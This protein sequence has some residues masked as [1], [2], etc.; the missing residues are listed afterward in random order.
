MDRFISRHL[1]SSDTVVTAGHCVR[2]ETCGNLV[3][4]FDFV[5]LGPIP[6]DIQITNISQDRV[7]FCKEIV[8]FRNDQVTDFAVVKVRLVSE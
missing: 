2:G 6:T 1:T 5:Q 3:F 8:A 7:Y 4:V